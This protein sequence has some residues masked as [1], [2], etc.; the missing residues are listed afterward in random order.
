MSGEGLYGDGDVADL[1]ERADSESLI[2]AN[3]EVVPM[4]RRGT[5]SLREE[6]VVLIESAL[7]A[8]TAR[9]LRIEVLDERERAEQGDFSEILS[10][11]GRTGGQ[12]R[13]DLQLPLMASVVAAL[14]ASPP[15]HHHS[16]TSCLHALTWCLLFHPESATSRSIY[17]SIYVHLSIYLSISHSFS[18]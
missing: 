10:P 13:F 15:Q 8:Q 14:G 2:M 5:A 17:L 11:L 4:P 18:L 12:R 6:G 9:D 1:D 16:H 3:A 7:S